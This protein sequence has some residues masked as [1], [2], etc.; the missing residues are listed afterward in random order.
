MVKQPATIDE[1]LEKLLERGCVVEDMSRARQVLEAVNYYRLAHYFTPFFMPDK[2]RYREGT[3]FEKVLRIYDFDREMR[4]TLLI[5]L[6]EI[7]INIRA[8]CSNYHALKYGALGYKNPD[9]FDRGHRRAQ[10]IANLNRLIETNS[11]S[12]MV[13]HHKGKYK[14][15]FP[16]WT[17]VEFF[18]FGMLKRFYLDLK[19]EDKAAIVKE[20]FSDIPI[21]VKHLNSWLERLAELRNRCAHYNRLYD[22][23]FHLAPKSTIQRELDNSLF[24][25]IFIMKQ[26]HKRREVWNTVIVDK[27]KKHFDNYADVLEPSAYGFPPDWHSVLIF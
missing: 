15:E 18:S 12:S 14:G 5:G 6:E 10:F 8:L 1:Q 21:N 20:G 19:P 23:A 25:Y 4:N 9:S 3:T 24:S 22:N 11:A 13:V 27:L 16:V 7:E 2:T 26:L 17:I